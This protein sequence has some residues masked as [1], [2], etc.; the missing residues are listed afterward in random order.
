MNV[1]LIGAISYLSILMYGSAREGRVL[2]SRVSPQLASPQK[3]LEVLFELAS[4][5]QLG[6]PTESQG[7]RRLIEA[8]AP[9]SLVLM[10]NLS[11]GSIIERLREAALSE[12]DF[13]RVGMVLLAAENPTWMF[14]RPVSHP[15]GDTRLLQIPQLVYLPQV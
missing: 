15:I 5:L 14:W 3:A 12:E 13:N 4:E 8:L 11:D 7:G 9:N 1:T 2:P 10:I 6:E